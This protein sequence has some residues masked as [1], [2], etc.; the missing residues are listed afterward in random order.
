MVIDATASYARR[1]LEIIDICVH[2]HMYIV[3]IVYTEINTCEMRFQSS[4]KDVLIN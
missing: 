3:C 4:L 2:M 1:I